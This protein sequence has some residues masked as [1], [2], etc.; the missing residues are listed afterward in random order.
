[1]RCERVKRG[2]RTLLMMDAKYRSGLEDSWIEIGCA[3]K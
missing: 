3:M 1:M 2:S